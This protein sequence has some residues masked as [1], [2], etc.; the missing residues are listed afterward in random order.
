MNTGITSM[1]LGAEGDDWSITALAPSTDMMYDSR[2]SF[3]VSEVNTKDAP[4]I[5]KSSKMFF[6]GFSRHICNRK[7]IYKILFQD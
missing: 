2:V 4:E 1:V 6:L 3:S 5:C 7:P